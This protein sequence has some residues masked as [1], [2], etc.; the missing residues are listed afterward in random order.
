MLKAR[1]GLRA[2]FGRAALGSDRGGGPGREWFKDRMKTRPTGRRWHQY[3]L[4]TL[5]AVI[6]V[7]SVGMSW[8]A[9][10]MEAAR[11]EAHA[12]EAI[13]ALGGGL[14]YDYQKGSSTCKPQGGPTAPGWL[15]RCLGEHFFADV[16]G[17]AISGDGVRNADLAHLRGLPDLEFAMLR[18]PNIDDSALEHLAG[19]AKLE[20]LEIR[21]T[22]ITRSAIERMGPALPDRIRIDWNGRVI[23]QSDR[24]R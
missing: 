22:P 19:C 9:M 1:K 6:F 13:A 7:A 18:C 4:R 11:R 16:V 15:R 23:R 14:F 3:R 2:Y 21:D 5:L 17:V 10:R 8:F 24:N 20:Y 12:A